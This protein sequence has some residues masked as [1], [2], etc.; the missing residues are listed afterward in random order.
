MYGR[1]TEENIVDDIL[2][3]FF[4]S[5]HVLY[6]K[7]GKDPG[8]NS[9]IYSVVAYYMYHFHIPSRDRLMGLL[10]YVSISCAAP[11]KKYKADMEH[12]S[13]FCTVLHIICCD[14]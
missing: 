14:I 9:R 3:I 5:L 1:I 6:V 10:I 11:V 4:I 2:H 13:F 7:Y 8:I 12:Q